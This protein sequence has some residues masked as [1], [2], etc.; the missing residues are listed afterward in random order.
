M[1]KKKNQLTPRCDS[2]GRPDE[3]AGIDEIAGTGAHYQ[4]IGNHGEQDEHFH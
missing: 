4:R 3:M 2:D 1:L